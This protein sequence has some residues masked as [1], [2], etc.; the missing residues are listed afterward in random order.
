MPAIEIAVQWRCG[1]S[2]AVIGVTSAA[3]ATTGGQGRQ[4]TPH[5]SAIDAGVRWVVQS[6][7]AD[8]PRLLA[9]A[10]RQAPWLLEQSRPARGKWVGYLHVEHDGRGIP[11]PR[12]LA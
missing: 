12:T 2:A 9:S 3:S 5:R 6:D 7:D 11:D 1:N 10:A 8:P 4:I